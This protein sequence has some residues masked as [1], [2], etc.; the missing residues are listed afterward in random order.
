MRGGPALTARA[1]LPNKRAHEV[2]EFECAGVRYV[3]G[4]GR[5][6]DGRLAEI[7][8]NAGKPGCAAE[9][10]AC[11]AAII[12]SIALQR[13]A[14]AADLRHSLTRLKSGEAAGPIGVLLDILARDA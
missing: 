13:G 3:A 6:A 9:A 5:F 1:R 10:A 2:I 8:C 14:T 4:V 11:D 12:A 7:F